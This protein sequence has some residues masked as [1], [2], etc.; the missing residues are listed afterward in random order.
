[1][2]CWLLSTVPAKHQAV[3]PVSK[4]SLCI[5]AVTSGPC[6][7]PD[8]DAD[9]SAVQPLEFLA[10][11]L[12]L[13]R[14][15]EVS[16]P[17]TGVALTALWRLLSSGVLGELPRAAAARLSSSDSGATEQLSAVAAQ[18]S[19]SRDSSQGCGYAHSQLL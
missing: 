2:R 5:H 13:V 15:P 3:P 8:S 19:S 9:W 18:Q 16:G 6:A 4:Q 12:K 14:E 17:I 7:V 10:P 11:F 1:M